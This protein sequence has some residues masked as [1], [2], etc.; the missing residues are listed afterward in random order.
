MKSVSFISCVQMTNV[1]TTKSLSFLRRYSRNS[2][3]AKSMIDVIDLQWFN[4]DALP[5]WNNLFRIS[6]N[7]GCDSNFD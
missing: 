2:C 6:W 4:K 1:S 5:T 3:H 7:I